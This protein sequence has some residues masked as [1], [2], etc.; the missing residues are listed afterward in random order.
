MPSRNSLGELELIVLLALFRLGEGAY[1]AAVRDE[2]FE[3]TGRRVTPGAIYPTLDRLE[4]KGLVRSYEGD[5][6]P[7][8]GGRAKRHFVIRRA[9][10]A[11][12]RRAWGQYA[13]LAEGVERVLGEGRAR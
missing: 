11:E 3:R 8:R 2:I 10:L 4:R 12:L 13:A 1:G 7:E 6:V 9:G 5:P